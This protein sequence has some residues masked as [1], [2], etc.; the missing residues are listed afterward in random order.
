MN[1]TSRDLI[2]HALRGATTSSDNSVSSIQNAVEEL[3]TEIIDRNKLIPSQIVSI[4]FTVT[5]DLDACFPASIAR[6]QKG[7]N[8]VA[9]ID[10]QQ[11]HVEGD[12]D[13]CIRSLAHVWLP[14]GQIPRHTYLRSASMLRPD[15]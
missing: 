10:C 11:M 12:L 1:S 5:K 2:L 15:R 8:N 6:H 9:L 13:F 14:N 4:I 3:I 7:W